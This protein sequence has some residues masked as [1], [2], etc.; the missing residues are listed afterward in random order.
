MKNA[1]Q[2]LN[3]PIC[4]ENEICRISEYSHHGF[5]RC[6]NSSK[7]SG[8]CPFTPHNT[9]VYKG[10]TF[11]FCSPIKYRICKLGE[12]AWENIG[13]RSIFHCYC[14]YYI[15]GIFNWTATETHGR[16]RSTYYKCVLPKYCRPNA[17]CK[18]K[19]VFS[20]PFFDVSFSG[21][22]F[23]PKNYACTDT[24]ETIEG[25]DSS[26]TRHLWRCLYEEENAILSAT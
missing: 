26:L 1:L 20:R 3:T 23:C 2:H 17:I 22:C 19:N 10:V 13:F 24:G 21:S 8:R 25:R 14:Q 7:H 6:P 18:I 11:T 4:Q 16:N 9:L 12:I 15:Q 5:C